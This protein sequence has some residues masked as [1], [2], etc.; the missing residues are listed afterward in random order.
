[1][2]FV[3]Y[4]EKFSMYRPGGFHPTHLGDTFSNGRYTVVHKLG[5]GASSTVW[6]VFDSETRSYVSL[7]ILAAKNRSAMELTA[8]KHLADTYDANDEGSRYVAHMRDHFVHE[9]PNG[10]HLCIVSEVQGPNIA[11]EALYMLYGPDEPVVPL[12]MAR[13]VCGQIAFGIAYLHKRGIAHGDLHAGNIL[14]CLPRPWTSMEEVEGVIGAPRQIRYE[15]TAEQRASPRLPDYLVPAGKLKN[16]T[17]ILRL[18][19]ERPNIRICDFS[20]AYMPG[21]R[22]PRRV[23]IPNMFRPPDAI[24]LDAPHATRELDIWA[25]AILFHIVLTGFGLFLSSDADDALTDMALNLGPFPEPLWS[26]WEKRA[27][28]FNEDGTPLGTTWTSSFL[29]VSGSKLAVGGEERRLLEALMAGMVR[30]RASERLS[31]QSVAE[32]PWI[33]EFC[34]PYMVGDARYVVNYFVW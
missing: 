30:Y 9:G 23:A 25:L 2:P 6:L 24:L 32:H 10:Q 33:A 5:Y 16:T 31:A 3:S 21:Q 15:K 17:E 20:E 14:F 27:K 19:L 18:C 34:H 1:M 28:W 13:R 7:K 4:A 8:L 12:N 22:N 11:E 29:K 26:K